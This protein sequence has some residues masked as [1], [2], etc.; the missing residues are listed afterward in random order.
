[1]PLHLPDALP[2]AG[3][4]SRRQVIGQ[5]RQW[6]ENNEAIDEVV[7]ALSEA[8]YRPKTIR[9]YIAIAETSGGNGND[10]SPKTDRGTSRTT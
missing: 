8:G 1:M 2:R 4:N 7:Q 5:V 10:I 6:L 3:L 9:E